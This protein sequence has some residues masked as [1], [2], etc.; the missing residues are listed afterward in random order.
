MGL[1]LS[2]RPVVLLASSAILRTML[3]WADDLQTSGSLRDKNADSHLVK[4]LL[5]H[6]KWKAEPHTVGSTH[7]VSNI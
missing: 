6:K 3:C 7:R 2:Q 4:L 5:D 1:D